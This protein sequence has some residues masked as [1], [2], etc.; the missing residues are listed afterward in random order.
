M[1]LPPSLASSVV[2]FLELQILWYIAFQFLLTALQMIHLRAAFVL[3]FFFSYLLIILDIVNPSRGGS[4][5]VVHGLAS[6]TA[7]VF[8]VLLLQL[9]SLP[10]M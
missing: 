8:D 2:P 3:R 10:L 5:S 6:V 4:R 7:L 9:L 1:S